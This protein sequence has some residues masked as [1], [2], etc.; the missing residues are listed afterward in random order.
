MNDKYLLA[1]VAF[2]V[3]LMMAKGN[4][5]EVAT[6]AHNEVQNKGDWWTYPGMWQAN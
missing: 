6:S 4:K 3:G 1:A 5:A 2:V